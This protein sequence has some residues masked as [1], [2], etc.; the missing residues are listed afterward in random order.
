MDFKAE[1]ILFYTF[2]DNVMLFLIQKNG[3]LSLRFEQNKMKVHFM[4]VE[5]VR[6]Y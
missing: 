3:R 4:T 1:G 5:R 6:I 2:N